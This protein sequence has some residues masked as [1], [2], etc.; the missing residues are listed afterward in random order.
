MKLPEEYTVK[1]GCVFAG[2][3]R[4]YKAGERLDATELP[5]NVERQL[6]VLESKATTKK[7]PKE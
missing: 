3:H 7:S 2:Q 5:M 6:A 4:Q 1:E